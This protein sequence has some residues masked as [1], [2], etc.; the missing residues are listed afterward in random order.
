MHGKRVK[1]GEERF[2]AFFFSNESAATTSARAGPASRSQAGRAS[3][4][5]HGDRDA[6]SA[7]LAVGRRD[8]VG[9]RGCRSRRDA[10]SPR[11]A[12]LASRP[13]CR[14]KG[15][16][17]R[18]RAVAPGGDLRVARGG[19][20]AA[21]VVPGRREGGQGAPRPRALSGGGG[22]RR[23]GGHHGHAGCALRGGRRG[24]ALVSSGRGR[25]RSASFRGA[26]GD[27]AERDAA[28]RSDASGRVRGDRDGGGDASSLRARVQRHRQTARL[29]VD[30]ALR[31]ARV[32]VGRVR[33]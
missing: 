33:G 12:R 18:A 8:A 32:A 16:I 19:R 15:A 5:R 22:G 27:D 13:A 3:G 4:Q 25:L 14:Q 11:A 9:R 30:R 17:S 31:R 28:G 10:Q 7:H 26:G 6:D 21:R 1:D 20:G 2:R 29:V 23:G 24:C